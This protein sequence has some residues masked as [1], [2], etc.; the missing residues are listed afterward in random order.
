MSL[1][2]I[3]SI[4]MREC[5]KD[6]VSVSSTLNELFNEFFSRISNMPINTGEWVGK[7]ADE[8]VRLARIDK[9][10]YINFNNDLYNLGKF[11]IEQSYNLENEIQK[12]NGENI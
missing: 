12:S 1:I 11:L 10:Q 9:A 3:D 6:I 7:S 2:N 4:K 8:F 5:G